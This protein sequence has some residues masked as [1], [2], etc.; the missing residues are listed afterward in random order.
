MTTN[1][2]FRDFI[3][4]LLTGLT[5]L[6]CIGVI[7]LDDIFTLTTCFF[8]K[9]QFVKEFSFL[10]TIFLI[11]FIYLTGHIIGIVDYLTMKYYVWLH[12]KLRNKNNWVA[13]SFLKINH[14]IFYRH[15]IVYQIVRH[16]KSNKEG[17]SFMTTEEFW[18][19][20]AKLQKENHYSPAEYWYILN[21]L[22][23]G[24]SLV[25]LISTIISTTRQQWTLATVFIILT[26]LFFYRAIQYAEFFVAT[27]CRLSKP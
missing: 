4:Y 5:L 25:F 19:L 21:D 6:L 17:K 24:V 9:Y 2:T 12:K 27:V 3:V 11:P 1:F 13:K 18:V 23:K 10:V 26:A 20:C 22:F 15:R 14:L 8:T 16:L 7:F